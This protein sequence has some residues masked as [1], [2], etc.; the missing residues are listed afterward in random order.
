MINEQIRDKEVRL[1][2][3]DGTQMGI[4]PG[5]DAQRIADEKKLDLVKISPT[6]K[7]PVCKIMD[8]SKFRFEQS[9][10]EKEARKKQRTI[11][12][13]ELRLSPNIDKHDIAVKLKKAL[14]FLKDGDKVKVAV[15]FRGRELGRTEVAYGIL[16][17]FA[18]KV[19]EVGNIEKPPKMEGRSM[20]MFLA[21]KPKTK[22]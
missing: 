10:K 16:N 8:Y 1:I 18:A 6:A 9:K 19:A 4:V 5:R 20:A 21:P 22:E 12:V 14:E 13:K 11:E 7:P 3:A 2:D 17:D 15:R